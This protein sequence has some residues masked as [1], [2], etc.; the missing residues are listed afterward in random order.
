MKSNKTNT[1]SD[2]YIWYRCFKVSDKIQKLLMCSFLE[3]KETV[4]ISLGP[5]PDPPRGHDLT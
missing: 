4:Y 1:D 5:L 2:A 3:I